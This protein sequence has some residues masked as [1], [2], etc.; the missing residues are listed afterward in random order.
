MKRLPLTAS[1]SPFAL[2][3]TAC[4]RLMALNAP[5]A[6]TSLMATMAASADSSAC[7]EGNEALIFPAGEKVKRCPEVKKTNTDKPGTAV[8]GVWTIFTLFTSDHL[9][10]L[11]LSPVILD[12]FVTQTGSF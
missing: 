3:P 1:S 5:L 8:G 12:I 10:V 7:P 6:Q 2:P 9:V 4:C 11:V